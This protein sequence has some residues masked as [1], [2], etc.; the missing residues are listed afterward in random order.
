MRER[1]HERNETSNSYS[2]NNLMNHTT[3]KGND[4][5]VS[6]HKRC[7]LFCKICF[8]ITNS[9]SLMFLINMHDKRKV[10]KD[11]AISGSRERMY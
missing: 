7:S 2:L 1:I 4:R 9:H 10:N 5:D 11:P 8:R 3:L 6:N